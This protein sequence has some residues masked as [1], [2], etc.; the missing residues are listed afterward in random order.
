MEAIAQGTVIQE[1]IVTEPFQ[2]RKKALKSKL[3]LFFK[4][5]GNMYSGNYLF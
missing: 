2:L 4:V 1:G 5:L 3:K